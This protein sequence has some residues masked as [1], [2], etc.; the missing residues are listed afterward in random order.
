MTSRTPLLSVL[1]SLSK[2]FAPKRSSL[3]TVGEN[4]RVF[5][6]MIWSTRVATVR[7]WIGNVAPRPTASRPQ[8]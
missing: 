5:D 8:L 6:S 7:S 1:R 2:M 4:V 3:T